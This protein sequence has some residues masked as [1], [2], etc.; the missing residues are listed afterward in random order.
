MN[1]KPKLKYN[2]EIAWKHKYA[3]YVNMQKLIKTAS[4]K[5][6]LIVTHPWNTNSNH[7]KKLIWYI[8]MKL[9]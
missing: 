5:M 8:N 9:C 1:G 7:P 6:S 4:Y 2:H 3:H